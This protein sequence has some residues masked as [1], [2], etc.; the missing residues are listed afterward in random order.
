MCLYQNYSTNGQNHSLFDTTIRRYKDLETLWNKG[1]RGLLSLWGGACN[2]A[3]GRAIFR[4]VIFRLRG[5]A[6]MK[7]IRLQGAEGRVTVAGYAKFR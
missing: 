6:W 5:V 3:V 4:F 1:L 2:W 7:V